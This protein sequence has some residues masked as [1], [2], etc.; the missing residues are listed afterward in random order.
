ME[1]RGKKE[2]VTHKPVRSTGTASKAARQYCKP[3]Q[4]K[5]LESFAETAANNF[6]GKV[7]QI[8][9]FEESK[10][11]KQKHDFAQWRSLL[12]NFD[13]TGVAE[14]WQ[15]L[16]KYAHGFP[17]PEQPVIIAA[18]GKAIIGRSLV[19]SVVGTGKSTNIGRQSKNYIQDGKKLKTATFGTIYKLVFC[20]FKIRSV[21][22]TAVDERV[23]ENV[24]A[25]SQEYREDFRT[26][27]EMFDVIRNDSNCVTNIVESDWLRRKNGR[28]LKYVVVTALYAG[29]VTSIMNSA[30][31]DRCEF[32]PTSPLSLQSEPADGTSRQEE[33]RPVNNAQAAD[34]HPS[35]NSGPMYQPDLDTELGLFDSWYPSDFDEHR[36]EN[37]LKQMADNTTV[38]SSNSAQKDVCDNFER[39]CSIG[40]RASLSTIQQN[41]VKSFL[42][43]RDGRSDI[44]F[45]SQCDFT[46]AVGW[47][48]K[49]NSIDGQSFAP[50]A[51][52]DLQVDYVCFPWKNV[53]DLC[54]GYVCRRADGYLPYHAMTEGLNVDNLPRKVECVMGRFCVTADRELVVLTRIGDDHVRVNHW[55]YPS[56]TVK[57]STKMQCRADILEC[58]DRRTAIVRQ[59]HTQ[60]WRQCFVCKRGVKGSQGLT[61]QCEFPRLK[62]TGASDFF[63]LAQALATTHGV[64]SGMGAHSFWDIAGEKL[65]TA[66][67]LQRNEVRRLPS[68]AFPAIIRMTLAASRQ[69]TLVDELSPTDSSDMDDF[70]EQCRVHSHCN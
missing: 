69:Y 28:Y 43:G 57:I 39:A 16:Y 35:W 54:I 40:D 15:A 10:S 60:F 9:L 5:Q 67:V 14:A 41:E 68:D 20:I 42:L 49:E 37:V 18:I 32:Q 34:I 44:D 47:V 66:S 65:L 56:T 52:A 45:I 26:L 2:Y 31:E 3:H 63:C 53:G 23:L 12:C 6:V 7:G 50:E 30:D 4:T 24:I 21:C 33:D 11:K 22:K 51:D 55:K 61:C 48:M 70:I 29:C 38:E 19:S 64:Y 58:E 1:F 25:P 13:R 36:A 17:A 8:P 59:T 27:V 46:N 62:F